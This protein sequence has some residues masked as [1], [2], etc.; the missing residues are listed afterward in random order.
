MNLQFS[1]PIVYVFHLDC[2]FYCIL[3]LCLTKMTMSNIA[4]EMTLLA[5]FMAVVVVIDYELIYSL[6]KL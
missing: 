3:L 1:V 4:S 5:C 6:C 2:T